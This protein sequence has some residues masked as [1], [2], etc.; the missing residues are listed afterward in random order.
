MDAPSIGMIPSGYKD[1]KL[2]SVY[3]LE[4]LGEELVTNGTF[5]SQSEVDYWS[6]A[7]SRATKSLE[8]GFMRLTYTSTIGAALFKSN[9]VPVGRY[10]V[11]FRAKG[12]AN[13][14]FASI[15]DNASIGNNP[16]YVISNPILTTDWQ[17]YDFEIELTQSTFRFYL[18]SLSIGN[19]LDIDDIS[20]K[21]DISADF[22]ITRGSLATRV[23]AQGLVEDVNII[24]EEL[25][26]NGDFSQEGSELIV[27]G[28]FDTDSDWIKSTGWSISG[29]KAICN[30]NGGFSPF[31]QA[32]I[33]TS[34]KR[35]KITFDFNGSG[36]T[37]GSFKL[38]GADFAN[39][40]SAERTIVDG[41]NVFYVEATSSDF[42]INTS[43]AVGTG[44]FDNISVKEVGQNWTFGTGWS[45]GD[46]KA[47][48][49]T[50]DGDGTFQSTNILTLNNTYRITFDVN[51]TDGVLRFES[52]AGDNFLISSSGTYTH[53]FEADLLAIKFRRNSTPTRGY[54]DNVSVKEITDATN[55][56]RLDYSDGSCPSLLLEPQ[57]TNLITY[58][59]DFSGWNR[60]GNTTINATN[61][62]SPSGQNNATN[63]TGLDGTGSNDLRFSPSSFNSA[64]KTL[65]FSVY[66]K[67][68]GTL[69]LQMSNGIDYHKQEIVTLTN[70]WK[71]H[72]VS[73]TFNSTNSGT[74]FHCNIDD[75]GATATSYDVWGAQL[76]ELPYAS[77]YIPTNGSAAT[78]LKDQAYR[79]GLSSHINSDEG[80]FYAE[81]AALA[82]D[83]TN[84]YIGISDGTSS[85]R[86][87]IF[88]DSNNVLKAFVNGISSISS[89]VDITNTNKVA[90]KYKSGDIALWVNGLEVGTSSSSIS[91]TGLNEIAF[92][93]H[94]SSSLF[95]KGKVK[96]LRVYKTALSDEDLQKLTS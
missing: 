59:E 58:S 83:G 92:S 36:V 72:K 44:I 21:E 80:V 50:D 11:T 88:F 23:N 76:E 69:R 29:G 40:S 15:G 79:D 17:E 26:Q 52:G 47:V 1:G 55:L 74:Q 2:Y 33:L 13:T 46:G 22:D 66:L 51:I 18:N 65:S 82:D 5:D 70:N 53:E 45:M 85:N 7:S 94:S 81:I 24:S 3:P 8:D 90:F 63:I 20:I 54:I 86:V 14:N 71:R 95:F 93:L 75:S 31:R 38:N 12:T 68:S 67:G 6:I 10:K 96:D 91:I 39:A 56:P 9:L 43:G 84:R 87:N 49:D 64:N 57:S 61:I 62:L 25:V 28:S 89:N 60:T 4:G 32:N 30:A 77:S 37:S 19:T 73:G 42:G 41:T 16:E 35:Y 27:N 34:G 78:R 48:F